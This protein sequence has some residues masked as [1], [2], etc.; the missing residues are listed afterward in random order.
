[1]ALCGENLRAINDLEFPYTSMQIHARIYFPLR[2]EGRVLRLHLLTAV[3]FYCACFRTADEW[4][5]AGT[6]PSLRPS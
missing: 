2:R 4:V 3:Q 6:R 5:P 1:M